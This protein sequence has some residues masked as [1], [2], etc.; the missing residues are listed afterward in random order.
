[1]KGSNRCIV[2]NFAAREPGVSHDIRCSM[3]ALRAKVAVA[4]RVYREFVQNGGSYTVDGI[5]HTQ[6]DAMWASHGPLG[7]H[8]IG[9]PSAKLFATCMHWVHDPCLAD[10]DPAPPVSWLAHKYLKRFDHRLTPR[11]FRNL[12]DA[13]TH[14]TNGHFKLFYGAI[15]AAMFRAALKL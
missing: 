5:C 14:F 12:V 9:K 4:E 10:D 13:C 2:R 3:G 8:G 6:F 11:V 1:M 7:H 15:G